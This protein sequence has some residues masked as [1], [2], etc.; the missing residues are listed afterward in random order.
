MPRWKPSCALCGTRR[1]ADQL[2]F[3]SFTRNRYCGP[4]HWKAC[5]RAATRQRNT[6]NREPVAARANETATSSQTNGG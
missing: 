2:V 1:P 6:E 3:S 5:H 4:R